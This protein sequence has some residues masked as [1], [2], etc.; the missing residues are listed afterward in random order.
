[1]PTEAERGAIAAKLAELDG[2]I[3][4]LGADLGEGAAAREALA[5]VEVCRKGAA[6]ALRF[7]EFFEAKDVARHLRTL[8]KGIARAG[9]LARKQTPWAGAVGGTVRGYR[10]KV[11]GSI[12]PYA[13]IVP[14]DKP[15]GG[16]GDD[17]LRLDVVL[18]GRDA[19]IQEARFF[20]AHDGKAAA[21]GQPGLILHVFG[22]GNNA[23]RWAG[24]TDVDEAIAAVRRNYWVDDRRIV[25]R[26]FSM[27]GRGG[28][29]PRA[30]PA[31][32]LGVGRGRRRVHRD[33]P[34]RQAQGPVADDPPRVAH[35][36]RRGLCPE[37]L[38]RPDR[39]L[40]RRERPAGAGVLESSRTRW[41][42]SVC[43]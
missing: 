9:L 10:S 6:W 15:G 13:V 26:G 16:S 40:W 32:P 1:M 39:R 5:D 8:D 37:R 30:A 42:R 21:D 2:L 23:Y 36:R 29:A 11:D 3:T 35:L 19:K 31:E 22:R 34:V 41:W 38:G 24:E 25:L 33:R 20:D 17:R 43:P 28:M 7:G 14:T 4:K 12:Q 18:H 27:G